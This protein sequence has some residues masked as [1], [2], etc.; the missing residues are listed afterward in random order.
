[1]AEDY[2][3]E[4]SSEPARFEK[5]LKVFIIFAGLCLG[6]ELIWLLGI[7][8]FR[9]FSRIDISGYD[10]IS[11]EEI[12]SIAGLDEGASFFTT[13]KFAVESALEGVSSLASVK[14]FKYFPGRLRIVLEARR[15]LAYSLADLNGRTVPVLF[16]SEGVIFEVGGKILSGFIPIISG[17]VIEE[18]VPGMRLPQ[19]F[20]P[21]LKE[22]EKIEYSSPELLSAVSEIKILRKPF[23]GF[24]LLMY[25]IHRKM[26]VRLSEVNED[27]LRYA[28]LMV[29]VLSTSDDG[30]N[31]DGIHTA[32]IDTLD[33]R[34]GIASY[35][36]QSHIPKEA[37]SEL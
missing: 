21:F 25:P 30:N 16:D 18:P 32:V 10:G 5:I 11:R 24:D 9:Q 14:V 29:D 4:G 7:S 6:G 28:L 37:S 23:D 1:M 15:P 34:S 26:K 20:V 12:L 2:V 3:L 8:P 13:D 17:L 27:I 36:Y 33:F 35:N 19:T 31:T 22:L